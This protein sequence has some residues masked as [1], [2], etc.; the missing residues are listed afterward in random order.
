V[1]GPLAERYMNA[2]PEAAQAFS[3]AMNQSS[4]AGWRAGQRSGQALGRAGQAAGAAT[5]DI[6]GMNES[7]MLPPG[8]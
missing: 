2:S 1:L 5:P 7:G 8:Y 3:A 4:L 6:S